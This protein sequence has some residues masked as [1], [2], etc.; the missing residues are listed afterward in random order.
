V[1]GTRSS[2]RNN[3]AQACQC[4]GQCDANAVFA[5]GA[6]G[7]VDAVF[8]AVPSLLPTKDDGGTAVP[9]GYAALNRER[10]ARAATRTRVMQPY[11]ESREATVMKLAE[12]RAVALDDRK[13]VRVLNY[14]G[15]V[16]LR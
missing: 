13:R 11:E 7:L 2:E 1:H 3:N 10:A 6:E 16:H 12:Q 8:N 14:L 5:T 9:A 15:R 4:H